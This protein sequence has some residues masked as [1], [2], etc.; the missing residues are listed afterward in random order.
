MNTPI[1]E[2][3][4]L[5]EPVAYIRPVDTAQGKSYAVCATDGTQL[6]LFS[7][8]EA[9]FFAAKQHDLDPVLTH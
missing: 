1:D 8:Q 6:A 2:I 4:L 7:S 9:A 3:S 5:F